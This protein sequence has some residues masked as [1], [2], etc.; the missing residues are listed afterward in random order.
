V[1]RV[2]DDGAGMGKPR[3]GGN[4]IRNMIERAS[5]L[6]GTFRIE[7]RAGSGTLVEWRV[8]NRIVD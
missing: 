5:V 4:G 6:G 7:P 1:L 3:A 2:S 8:P